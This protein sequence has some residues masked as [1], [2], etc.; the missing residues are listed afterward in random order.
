MISSSGN[1]A[2]S[3]RAPFARLRRLW[4]QHQE[5]CGHGSLRSILNWLAV[6]V[7]RPTISCGWIEHPQLFRP[8]RLQKP[9]IRADKRECFSGGTTDHKATCQLD[10]V[11]GAQRIPINHLQCGVDHGVI[12]R[13][14]DKSALHVP[15]KALENC[16]GKAGLDIPGALPSSDRGTDFDHRNR[17][18]SKAIFRSIADQMQEPVCTRLLHD[19]FTS[20][21]VSKKYRA[22]SPPVAQHRRGQSL[23]T[24][25]DRAKTGGLPA[26]VPSAALTSGICRFNRI[27]VTGKFGGLGFATLLVRSQRLS[28][29]SRS[30]SCRADSSKAQGNPSRT[31]AAS[32]NHFSETNS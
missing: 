12:D 26:R 24:D 8:R 17:Q 11:V 7:R 1:A 9:M 28:I 32:R 19:N 27:A 16:D 4:R 29:A 3:R 5:L 14:P 15:L 23:S 18:N 30:T 13:L 2:A 31:N 6:L 10:G 22:K 20:A 25:S 21:L